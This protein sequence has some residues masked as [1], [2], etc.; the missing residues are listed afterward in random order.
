MFKKNNDIYYEK[1][2]GNKATLNIKDFIVLKGEEQYKLIEDTLNKMYE[3]N[4][5]VTKKYVNK[6]INGI[7]SNGNLDI[8]LPHNLH[9][10]KLDKNVVFSFKKHR[11]PMIFVIFAL[12][13]ALLVGLA[14]YLGVIAYHSRDLNIDLNGDGIA[15]LNI[16]LDGDG[17][18]DINCDSNG[19]KRPDY[20]IDYRGNRKSLFNVKDKDGNIINRINID[21]DGDGICDLNCDVN[22]DNWPDTNLD[23]NNTGLATV[24]VDKNNDKVPELNIDTDGDMISNVNI[25]K[26]NDGLC[27]YNC[28]YVASKD[29]KLDIGNDS[30]NEGSAALIIR[31][32]DMSGAKTVNVFPDDQKGDVT[33]KIPDIKFSVENYSNDTIY[34]DINWANIVNTFESQN[35]WFKVLSTNGGYSTEYKVAPFSSGVLASHIAIPAD[36]KQEYTISFTL[37]GTGG[38]QNYDQGKVFQGRVLVELEMDKDK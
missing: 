19:D 22:G 20:N 32:E 37:H 16:D 31:Y 3:N 33:T 38:E 18:C 23:F 10:E 15:D 7:Y 13:F 2:K 26:D 29:G 4:V 11:N 1:L 27:D 24:N 12:L 6:I 30:V 5:E 28:I 8:F 14:T 34:Y 17:I 36:T 21:K 35:F 25:D 9:I